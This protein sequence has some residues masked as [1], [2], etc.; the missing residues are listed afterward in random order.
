MSDN[1]IPI[2]SSISADADLRQTGAGQVYTQRILAVGDTQDT[3]HQ[4][5]LTNQRILAVLRAMNANL[6][7]FNGLA[8]EDDFIG[9]QQEN[10]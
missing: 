7:S 6:Q 3:L 5:L 1:A 2:I 4:L 10:A 9:Q 8:A